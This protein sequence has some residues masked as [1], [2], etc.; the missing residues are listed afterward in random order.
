MKALAA[1]T[2]TARRLHTMPGAGP[3]IALSIE[4]FAPDMSDFRRGRDF[5]AWLGLVPRQHSSGGKDRTDPDRENQERC[6][7]DKPVIQIRTR[8]ADHQTDQRLLGA[9]HEKA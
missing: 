3:L 4:A 1:Q 2:D 8:S 9:P 6:K 5:A 7:G